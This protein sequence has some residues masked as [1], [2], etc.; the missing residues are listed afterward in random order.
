MHSR[1]IGIIII[2]VLTNAGRGCFTE[3]VCIPPPEFFANPETG[4]PNV[5]IV[6]GSHAASEDVKAATLLATTI[7]IHQEQNEVYF[8]RAVHKNINVQNM[9]TEAREGLGFTTVDVPDATAYAIQGDTP[10]TYTLS[11]LWYFDDTSHKFWGN[12]DGQFQPWETHEEIQ[13]RFDSPID[14]PCVPYLYGYNDTVHVPGLIYRADNIVVPPSI[15]VELPC[16]YPRPE[17][18][19]SL[20]T[21]LRRRIVAVPEPWLII[22]SMLPQFTLFNTLYTVVDGGPI[23]DTNF[24]TG[25]YGPL[26]GT[27]SILTGTPHFETE[28]LYQGKPVHF[29]SYTVELLDVYV[30]RNM[31]FFQVSE[32][33]E[34]IDTFWMV[35]DPLYGFS[36]NLQK[37]FPF[38]FYDS[39]NDLNGNKKVDPGEITDIT[40]V[41]DE[42]NWP[43]GCIP[44]KWIIDFIEDDT[45]M[46]RVMCG[47]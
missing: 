7:G 34:V 46:T 33:G 41:P 42:M 35:L 12:G 47:E 24:R 20:C 6:V 26:F 5:I 32:D 14:A 9:T 39:C 23:Q 45:L 27:P 1:I 2:C 40:N 13:I 31:G 3:E 17:A 38:G 30:K 10:I 36:T 43:K 28:T 37:K 19:V 25:E 15:M 16:C 22:H 18:V 8:F 11:S 29:G 4:E 44:K 21:C